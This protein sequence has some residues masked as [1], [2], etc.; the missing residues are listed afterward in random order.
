MHVCVSHPEWTFCLKQDICESAEDSWYVLKI[1]QPFIYYAKF[2]NFAY[3]YKSEF[4]QWTHYSCEHIAKAGPGVG[5]DDK[6]R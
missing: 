6:S 4:E 1:E 5:G 3:V 2:L